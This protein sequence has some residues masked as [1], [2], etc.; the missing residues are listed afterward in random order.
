MEKTIKSSLAYIGR[1]VEWL[2][3][4]LGVN[5]GTVYRRFK[6]E[7]WTLPQLRTMK[8]LFGWETLEG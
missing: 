2:A 6:D 4:Q 3:E 1:N 7:Q 8:A 5:Q